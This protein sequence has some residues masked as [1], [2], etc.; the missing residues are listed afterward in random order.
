MQFLHSSLTNFTDKLVTARVT[1]ALSVISWWSRT[2]G[3]RHGY[4]GAV[5]CLTSSASLNR[6]VSK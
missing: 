3:A 6:R 1:N 4:C 2:G 5:R